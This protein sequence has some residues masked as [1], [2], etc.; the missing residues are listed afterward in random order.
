MLKVEPTECLMN[1]A[2][3]YGRKK[4][5]TSNLSSCYQF[6]MLFPSTEMVGIV[7]EEGLGS[8][9][10]SLIWGM[11]SL[12]CPLHTWMWIL[13][14]RFQWCGRRWKPDYPPWGSGLELCK[15]R[16]KY[17]LYVLETWLWE[18]SVLYVN[19]RGWIG[20]RIFFF[21]FKRCKCVH[22]SEESSENP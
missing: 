8:K 20:G 1:W 5:I 16:L 12:N 2:V 13:T 11:L 10:G 22:R 3:G 17:R 15:W 6:L 19:V 7:G 14:R 18:E 9:I 4:R 21:S